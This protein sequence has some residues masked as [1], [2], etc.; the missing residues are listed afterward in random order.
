MRDENQQHVIDAGL[1]SELLAEM[2]L[3]VPDMQVQITTEAVGRY[4]PAEQRAVVENVM[5]K[6]VS[7]ALKEMISDG[8]TEAARE[9][10][11]W[12]DE[13]GIAVQHILYSPLDLKSLIGHRETGLIP[14]GY[15]QLMLVLGRYT[16]NQESDPG[17][18]DEFLSVMASAKLEADWA[19]CAFGKRELECLKYA[20]DKGGKIRIGFENS[21]WR[22]DGSIAASNEER[23]T[24]L[25]ALMDEAD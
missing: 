16:E 2:S 5:P 25:I 9:F 11:H 18:L 23:V 13:A 3:Q 21:I 12:A 24:S 1:Y 20:S 10:Y 14:G 4:S 15:I 17:D 7:V 8:D 6:S 22:A 19:V